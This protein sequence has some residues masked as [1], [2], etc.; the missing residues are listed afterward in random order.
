MEKAKA[1]AKFNVGD[2]VVVF[3]NGSRKKKELESISKKPI[4][5]ILSLTEHNAVLQNITTKEEFLCD[6][7]RLEFYMPL[8]N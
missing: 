7:T 3:A 5:K 2:Y 6:F 8:E 1:K 4:C